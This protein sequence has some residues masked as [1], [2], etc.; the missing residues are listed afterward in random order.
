MR[1]KIYTII[2]FLML[3]CFI[4]CSN[5][6]ADK[7]QVSPEEVSVSFSFGYSRAIISIAPENYKYTLQGTFAGETKE[8]C[9]KLSYK[10][11]LQ[12]TYEVKCGEWLFEI[13]AYNGNNAVY[14]D[15]KTVTINNGQNNIDFSLN[16]IKG[17]YGR[18]SV[19]L[20]FP[21]N[22]GVAKVTAGLYEDIAASDSGS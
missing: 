17:G 2:S 11:F 16:A 14:S 10:G 7:G 20:S 19:K 15:S 18:V 6:L 4:S 21:D 3:F 8:F 5:I 22:K 9:K 12:K 13:T 1:T